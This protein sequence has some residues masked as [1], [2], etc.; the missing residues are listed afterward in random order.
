MLGL[1]V[2]V[3]VV[4]ATT[5][6]VGA[7]VQGLVGLGLGLVAAPVTALV[8]PALMPD[9]LLWMAAMLPLVTLARER[10]HVDWRGLAWALPA[11][12]PGTAVGVVCV[13][14]FSDQQ[15]GVAVAL[16]VLLAVLVTAWAVVVPVTIATLV[17][18]GF[19]SGVAGTSTSVGGPPLAVLYQHRAPEQIRCTLAVYFLAGA[20]LSLAGLGAAGALEAR[21][22]LLALLLVPCLVAGFGLSRLVAT[23]IRARHV[24][25]AVLLVCATSALVLLVRSLLG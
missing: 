19:V 3:V 23:R 1:D 6:T 5:L 12:V 16:M 4:L 7:A 8:A 17:A 9:L 15:L 14:T 24:R 18:A 13:A 20:V 11:R 22:G 2:W 25:P 10:D 21:A